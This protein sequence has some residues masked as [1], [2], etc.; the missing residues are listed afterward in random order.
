MHVCYAL[1]DAHFYFTVVSPQSEGASIPWPIVGGVL[2]ALVLTNALI[3]ATI[4]VVVMCAKSRHKIVEG[5]YDLPA[6]YNKAPFVENIMPPNFRMEM[7]DNVPSRVFDMNA[8]S[9][10]AVVT[11]YK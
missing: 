4:I 11:R 8:N 10:Y 9:A 5:A 6:N 7:N 1:T 3:L 2:D